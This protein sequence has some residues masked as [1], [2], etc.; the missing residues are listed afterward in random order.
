[1]PGGPPAGTPAGEQLELLRAAARGRRQVSSGSPSAAI[2]ATLPVARVAVDVLPPHLDRPFD[3]AVPGDLDGQVRPGVR[4]R[5]RFAGRDVDGFVLDRVAETDHAGPLT[6]LRRVVAPEPVLTP[7][8]LALARAVA[9]RYAGTLADVLRLAVPPRHARTE[10][11]PPVVPAPRAPGPPADPWA[12]YPAG[13]AF[14]A[15]LRS[16]DAPRAVW[17]AP[18]GRR[19]ADAVAEAVV[20]T[21]DRGRGALVVV[22]DRRDLDLLE[23]V[24]GRR[25]AVPPA[26]LEADLGPAARY[27]AFLSVLR[28]TS[29][30]AVGTR[31]A[32]FAPVADLGLVVLWDDGDDQHAEARAPYPHAREVLVL[33][34]ELEG[35]AMLLGSWSRT[36]EAELLVESGWARP[37]E[38]DRAVRRTSWPQVRTA[39]DDGGDPLGAAARIPPVAW[40]VA[41]D[42]LARGSVLVQV[43]RAGYLPG[44]ACASCRRPA[45]CP[46]C[47]GPLQLPTAETGEAARCGWCGRAWPAWACPH[48]SGR[49]LRA[50]AVGVERTAEE[51]GRA[52]PG[53]GV[54][55]SRPD[56]E[57]PAV[58]PAGALVL[59]TSGVEPFAPGG[60]A[61]ALLLD[62]DTLLA[63]PDLRAAEEAL[64]RWRAAAALVRPAVDGGVVVLVA[65]PAA[66][67]SQ[68]LVRGDPTGHAARDLAERRELRL[69][70][71][72]TVAAVTGDPAAVAAFVAVTELPPGTSVLGPVPVPV[73]RRQGRAPAEGEAQLRLLLRIE[74]AGRLA[75]AAA[76]R[77]ALAVRSARREPGVVR[78]RFDPRDLG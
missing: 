71:G 59:A 53:A 2:A 33:R 56:R 69:P 28:G 75:L 22:P 70:P 62:G 10:R 46:A 12:G 54:V 42:A 17:T 18:P 30:V 67:A 29:R 7:A 15:R 35:A 55:V 27:R 78:V 11:E 43:P 20:A 34:A 48:C 66:P 4:V 72:A 63:R 6:P 26:R 57:L 9:D 16:G 25:L 74:P 52:F 68:A 60:Y 19:W 39:A 51:L 37:L 47:S 45:R 50:T 8:V 41:H 76:L 77:A 65:D 73:P 21:H 23:G 58:P 14:L 64:R 13:P 1:V 40:R 5:V 44:V 24:L 61:A 38:P 36:A 3:Y 49:R 32:A 31:A